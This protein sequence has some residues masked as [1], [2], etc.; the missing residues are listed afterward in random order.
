MFNQGKGRTNITVVFVEH[1]PEYLTYLK[2][3]FSRS[4]LVI[5]EEP[6]TTELIKVLEGR[7][8]PEEYAT[9]V[10]TEF[11]LYIEKQ[12][13]I[14]RELHL[15]G[16]HVIGCEPYLGKLIEIYNL[17][18]QGID[19]RQLLDIIENDFLMKIVYNVENLVSGKLIEYYESLLTGN[20]DI[21]VSSIINY[22][23]ADAYRVII[24]DTLRALCVKDSLSRLYG[25]SVRDIVIE[26]G[27]VH[28][29]FPM[30]LRKMLGRDIRCVNL[31][32]ILLRELNL[33]PLPHPGY[34]LSKVFIHGLPYSRNYIRLLAARCFVYNLFITKKEYIPSKE[35]AF[36]HIIQ[37]YKVL[38]L[39]NRLNYEDCRNI[40]ERYYRS[41]VRRGGRDVAN[42]C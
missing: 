4:D 35:F 29:T 10:Y 6:H 21:V 39:V 3:M 42:S 30:I 13:E 26:A 23:R 41:I 5:L 16:I 19:K 27:V 9:R 17:I 18:S 24:R 32:M 33:R 11:Q 7:M 15:R 22:A 38:Q 40:Y 28:T 14:L 36:P 34:I 31:K 8:T 1:R 20:F 12:V 37:E 25:R 2:D